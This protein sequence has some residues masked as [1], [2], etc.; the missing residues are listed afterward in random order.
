MSELS[1]MKEVNVCLLLFSILVTGFLLIGAI[2]APGRNRPFMKS[3]IRLLIVNIVMQTG[4]TGIWIFEGSLENIPLLKFC[5]VLSFGGGAL[6]IALFIRCLVEFFR[7]REDVSLFPVHIM[8]SASVVFLVLVIISAFNGMFFTV[9]AQG[10]MIGGPLGFLVN[11]FDLITVLVGIILIVR[12]RKILSGPGFWAL[13]SYCILPLITMSMVDIWYPTPEYLMTTLSMIVVFIL[14]HGELTRQL[15]EREKELLQKEL[16]LSRSKVNILMSQIEPHFLFNSLSTIKYL[17]RKEPEEAMEAVDEFSRFLRGSINA[18]TESG[19]ITFEKEMGF[20]NSYLH[21]EKR[22]FGDR[23]LVVYNIQSKGFMVPPLSIQTIVE[24][25]VRHGI[26]KK[27]SGGTLTI[28]TWEDEQNFMVSVTDDGI[29]FE[30]EK[31]SA[32]GRSHVGISN[33]KNR[34]FLMCGGNI[35]I[36]SVPGEGTQVTFFIPKDHKKGVSLHENLACR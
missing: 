28:A 21:L 24:N 11:L 1:T 3:F 22:R 25:A 4:E 27:L 17:C 2:A 8:M 18:M 23:I 12:H 29:G 34:L 10:R 30:M 6:L 26:S 15:T 13:M 16:E 35:E 19:C 31:I 14:F 36:H 20:I 33:A 32:D 7:E 5:C 9:D